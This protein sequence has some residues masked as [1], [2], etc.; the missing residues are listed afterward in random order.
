MVVCSLSFCFVFES[1]VFEYSVWGGVGCLRRVGVGEG[2]MRSC[3]IAGMK[4]G[5]RGVSIVRGEV[6]EDGEAVAGWG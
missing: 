2:R 3:L 1:E 6:R 5:R 4:V